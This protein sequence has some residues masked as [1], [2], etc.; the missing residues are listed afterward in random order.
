L[1][2]ELNRVCELL[3]VDFDQA[4]V[5]ERPVVYKRRVE[6]LREVVGDGSQNSEKIGGE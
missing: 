3:A 5:H 2:A 6:R 1:L 4:F